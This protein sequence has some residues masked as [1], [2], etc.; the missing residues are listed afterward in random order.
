MKDATLRAHV[1]VQPV[2][3]QQRQRGIGEQLKA[4]ERPGT[5]THRPGICR[6]EPGSRRS[7]GRPLPAVG[8]SNWPRAAPRWPT[9]PTGCSLPA[10]PRRS[11]SSGPR[12]RWSGS[13]SAPAWITA[14]PS[15]PAASDSGH[16]DPPR[17]GAAGPGPTARLRPA[18]RR[19]RDDQTHRAGQPLP[20]RPARRRKVGLPHRQDPEGAERWAGL[21]AADTDLPQTVGATVAKGTWLSAATAHYPAVVLGPAPARLPPSFKIIPRMSV[22]GDK[23]RRSVT[24][25]CPPRPRCAAAWPTYRQTEPNL[26]TR[27][28]SWNE[29]TWLMWPPVTVSTTTPYGRPRA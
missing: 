11:G 24:P 1:R 19:S 10:Y 12:P 14:R 4:A 17:S 21:L 3:R 18:R 28:G 5:R 22:D 9:W 23:R 27:A 8:S 25:D 6:V 29:T 26:A 20:A 2:R 7:R 13:A 16:A 15:S